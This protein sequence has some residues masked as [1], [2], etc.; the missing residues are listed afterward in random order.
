MF[1]M[2]LWSLLTI[3]MTLGRIKVAHVIRIRY[4]SSFSIRHTYVNHIVSFLSRTNCVKNEKI[5]IVFCN[6]SDSVE[7]LKRM[8]KKNISGFQICYYQSPL[9][10]IVYLDKFCII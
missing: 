10:R 2:H 8:F 5:R 6:L 4:S 3:D 9:Q 7:A 1:I